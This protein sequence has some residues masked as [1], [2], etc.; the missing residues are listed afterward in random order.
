MNADFPLRGFVFCECQT[1][2]TACW[3]KGN[4][5]YYP[6]Y[7]CPN[8]AC[9]QYGKAIRRE[10]LEGSSRPFWPGWSPRRTCFNWRGRCLRMSGNM[11]LAQL[12]EAA[13]ALRTSVRKVEKQIEALLDRIVATDNASVISAYEKRIGTLEQEKALAQEQARNLGKPEHTL[14]ETLELSL[15]FLANPCNIWKNNGLEWK[16]TGA[17]AGLH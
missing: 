10:M 17:P 5:K 7:H 2:L 14:E 8:R 12:G 3:T 15:Q 6:Y 11:R 4:T 16:R 13:A 9:D 1:P